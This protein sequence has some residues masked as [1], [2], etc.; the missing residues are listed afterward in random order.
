MPMS[1]KNLPRDDLDFR[2]YPLRTCRK[3]TSVCRLCGKLIRKGNIYRDGGKGRRAHAR[4]A[5]ET[6]DEDQS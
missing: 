4:C 5:E 2:A 1:F 3:V 6:E